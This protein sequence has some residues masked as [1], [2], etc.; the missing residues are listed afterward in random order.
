MCKGW[1]VGGHDV[2]VETKLG[3]A[4]VEWQ[5]GAGEAAGWELMGRAIALGHCSEDSGLFRQDWGLP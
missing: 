4:A 1:E 2:V 5:D 3:V